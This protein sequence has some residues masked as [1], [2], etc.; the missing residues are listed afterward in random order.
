MTVTDLKYP[1]V[2]LQGILKF[3][4]VHVCCSFV[5]LMK[6]QGAKGIGMIAVQIKDVKTFM[7]KLLSGDAFDS[8]L[9]E[10][11]QIRTFNTFT[12]DGY[13]N[14]EFFTKEELEDPQICPY[15][16]SKWQEMKSIC[17][18]LIKGKKVP[19]FLK[20]TLH[21]KPEEAQTLLE[22]GSVEI[23]A[24]MLKA[25]VVTVKYD[26]NGLLLTTGTSFATFVM[27]KTPDMLWDDA[28]RKFLTDKGIEFEEV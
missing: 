21:T 22:E 3:I 19:T 6:L 26:S 1:K 9:L 28:F 27:D 16:Y 10:E 18:Q 17:F 11:A 5:E 12:I 14:K 20:I 23:A 15:E 7:S 4:T 13:R 25:F 8:F 24:N 2:R